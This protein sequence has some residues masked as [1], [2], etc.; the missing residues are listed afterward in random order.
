[1][2]W[3]VV[4]V[5]L[6]LVTGYFYMLSGLVAPMWAVFILW[7]IWIALSVQLF[8]MRKEGPKQLL[9]PLAAA[10]IW[11]LVLWLGDVALGWTA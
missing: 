10:A 8:K 7:T 6:Q 1:M 9:V 11:F 3:F 2:I 4:A 5:I